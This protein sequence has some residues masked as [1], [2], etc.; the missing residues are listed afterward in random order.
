MTLL[1]DF[2]NQFGVN[3]DLNEKLMIE[4]ENRW[5]LLNENLREL[6][7]DSFFYAGT[8]LGKVKH[9][10]FFPSFILLGM[11]A[12][13]KGNKILVD[14]R[15]EWLFVCGRDVFRQGV[16][17]VQGSTEKGEYALVLNQHGECLGF[18]KILRDIDKGKGKVV[19]RNISDLGDFLRRE[20]RQ[21]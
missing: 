7:T 21:G 3:L 5:F 17:K 4:K 14:T 20:K 6:I 9:T 16:L 18:G 8:Y 15:T 13:K 10:T 19:L 11:I 12:E 1:K 2:L